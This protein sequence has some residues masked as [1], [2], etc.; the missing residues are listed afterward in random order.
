M[1]LERISLFSLMSLL[2]ISALLPSGS[3]FGMPIKH[4]FFLMTLVSLFFVFVNNIK[5]PINF[6]NFKLIFYFSLFF[7][8]IIFLV[9]T[10][11][12]N[13]DFELSL[14]LNDFQ[15]IMVTL[16]YFVLIELI[17]F[18]NKISHQ[19]FYNRILWF[20]FYGV[21]LF[22]IFKT[23]LIIFIISGIV[24]YNFIKSTIFP[25]INYEPVGWQISLVG[26]RF[27]FVTL[28]LLSLIVFLLIIYDW[29]KL[30]ISRISRYIFLVCFLISIFAAYSRLLFV[31]LAVLLVCTYLIKKRYLRLTLIFL[32]FA[33]IIGYN[34]DLTYTILEH[35][36]FD[37]SNSD[38]HRNTMIEKLSN[39]WSKSW[40]LGHGYGAY[41]PGYA[42][43]SEVYNYELQ[44]LSIFM[45]FGLFPIILLIYLELSFIRLFLKNSLKSIVFV[46]ILFNTILFASFTN[47]YLFS[48]AANVMLVLIYTFALSKIEH[49]QLKEIKHA[50]K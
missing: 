49:N 25:I 47:Q 15:D 1:I 22:C 34:F 33:S 40:I 36:F 12:L 8:L 10:P 46:F 48:A 43:G 38:S 21:F 20:S 16:L 27:S 18:Y 32:L 29:K 42:R 11:F 26:S 50:S 30:K 13:P 39:H 44:L 5:Q 19:L 14:V 17:F 37:Q 7:L 35:R 9:I 28:D 24:D 3:L 4:L 31:L 6:N 23:S 41:V 45:R 2:F